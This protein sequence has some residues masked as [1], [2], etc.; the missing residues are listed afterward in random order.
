M[1]SVILALSLLAFQPAAFLSAQP[2]WERSEPAEQLDLE[3]FHATM[4][5][6]F[7]TTE[8][9]QKGD[10]Q[11]EISHRFQVPI[12][13]GYDAFWGL[14]GPVHIRIGCAYGITDRFLTTVARSNLMGNVDLQL[15]Y[16]LLQFRNE[17]VPSVVSLQGGVGWNTSI[18]SSLDR[19]RTDPKN[20]QPYVQL[21]SNTMFWN[22]KLGLGIVPS[23]LYNSDIF[24]QSNEYTFTLGQ[25][26]Q[27]YL[28][29]RYSFWVEF[30]PIVSGY[31]GPIEYGKTER[32]YNSL[33]V[34]FDV[35]TGGHFFHLFVTNN[36]RLNPSQFL[37]GADSPVGDGDWR[38][39]FGIT[40]HL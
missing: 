31:Q 8:G 24:S 12:K 14:D 3:L 21:V 22:R 30:N 27:Y 35:E 19:S 7:P 4:T 28:N 25:Y 36:S 9:L 15:R 39:A 29:R 32:S 20:F 23:Y 40:R 10:F 34:G 17:S 26:L 11:F 1:R 2:Q 33:A 5:G 13:E 16:R 38:I 37:V 6:N 18:P